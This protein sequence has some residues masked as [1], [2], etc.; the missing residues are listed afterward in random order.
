[1]DWGPFSFDFYYTEFPTLIYVK[2]SFKCSRMAYISYGFRIWVPK[3]NIDGYPKKRRVKLL[4][5]YLNPKTI[6]MKQNNGK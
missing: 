3:L 4:I 6:W 2:M 5:S 1:M